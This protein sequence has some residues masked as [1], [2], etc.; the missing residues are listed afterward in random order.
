MFKTQRKLAEGFDVPVRAAARHLWT[1]G[2]SPQRVR[3]AL[4]MVIVQAEE[5]KPRLRYYK[6]SAI[7][8]AA[9]L[10]LKGKD[11]PAV[12]ALLNGF[13]ETANGL[14]TGTH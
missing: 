12:L 4:S 9:D 10:K 13:E 7:L 5:Q 11:Y 6:A 3:T 1:G 2:H 8:L 14:P